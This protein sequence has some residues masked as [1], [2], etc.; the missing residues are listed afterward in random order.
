MKNGC[1]VDVKLKI[2]S[3]IYGKFHCEKE[4]ISCEIFEINSYEAK[5]AK[6]LCF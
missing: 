5:F 2:T 1:K 4:I 6:D 3:R